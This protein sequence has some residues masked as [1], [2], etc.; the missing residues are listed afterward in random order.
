M[1]LTLGWL[2]L[3]MFL[4]LDMEKALLVYLGNKMRSSSN[5]S[6]MVN[7]EPNFDSCPVLSVL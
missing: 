1:K 5:K 2:S 4:P 6:P 3:G 7:K